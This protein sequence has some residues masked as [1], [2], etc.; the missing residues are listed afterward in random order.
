MSC[1]SARVRAKTTGCRWEYEVRK[2]L[3]EQRDEALAEQHAAEE[4]GRLADLNRALAA[5]NTDKSRFLAAASHD[6][7]QPVHAYQPVRRHAGR[8][9]GGWRSATW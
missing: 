7:E 2:T 9:G 6:L 4:R 1:W 8:A 3:V 5:I